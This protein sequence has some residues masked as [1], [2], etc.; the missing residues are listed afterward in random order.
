MQKLDPKTDGA[1]P[2]LVEE[3]IE[4]LRELFP[5]AFTESSDPDGPRW[6]VDFDALREVLGDQIEQRDERYG[7]TWHGK[8]QARRLAQMP[9]TGT[10][11]PCSEESVNWDSTENLFIEGDN[12]E[13]LKLLQKSYHKQVKMIY[14]DPPYNTGGEFVYTDRFQDNLTNYLRYTGQADESGA[15]WSANLESSG[16]YHTNWLNMMYP[17][18][19]LGRSLL[20]DDGFIVVSIDDAEFA[21]LEYLMNEIFGEENRLAVLV[22]DRNRKNDAKF[23]SVG[24]E[25]MVVYARNQARLRE[26]GVRLRSP[27][28]GIEEVRS[29][30]ERLKDLHGDDWAAIR[31]GI[32][33][34]YAGFDEDDPRYPLARFTK[35][36]ERGPYRT[37]GDP[38][39]PGGGGPRYDVPHP[40]TGRPCKVPSRG[41]VWPTYER[42][43]E[44]I[45]KGN[46]VFGDDE[47]TIPSVRRDLF[48][49]D[50]QV[51]RSVI[52]SYAQTT[53]QN[54]KK[55]FDNRKVFDNPKEPDDI[56]RLVRYLT[57]DNDLVVDYFAGSCTTAEAVIALNQEEQSGR[58]FLCVQLPEP[59]VPTKKGHKEAYDFCVEH[60]LD[61]NVASLGRERIRRV[62][63]NEIN[64]GQDGRLLGFNC[65]RLD[66]SNLRPWEP[67]VDRLADSLFDSVENIRSDR[68]ERDVLYEVVLKYGLDLSVPIEE[69]WVA[70]CLVYVVGAG[71]LFVCLADDIGL[72]VVRGIA[73]LKAELR[74]EV[75]RVV[76]KD[77]GFSDDV[78][79]TNTVQILQQA[80]IEDV[81]S[82]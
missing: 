12:L 73:A 45:E 25:Y 18:L 74:P 19:R 41:W 8:A 30:F 80:G 39:W 29:E 10:L 51:M 7:L 69:K 49:K 82:L 5:E 66:R 24:H 56:K 16:R 81:R 53:A 57:D 76:F 22:L 72:D 34:L 59:F 14:I 31:E 71:A 78:I 62:I 3:N 58:R 75:V 27:K 20:R 60:G 77:A 67:D 4:T 21:N 61:P 42:M 26:L 63:G 48:S 11:R 54:F 52:F 70:G 65:F 13:V 9:S 28:E 44:E 47:T 43:R 1:S 17:R 32:L 23:F 6:K 64:R 79:K 46:I 68:T 2:D 15:P 35:V 38:S 55:L 33:Q 50:D 40:V 36:D 37:D